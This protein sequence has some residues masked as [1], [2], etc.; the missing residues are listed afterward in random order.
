MDKTEKNSSNELDAKKRKWLLIF[1]VIIL[2]VITASASGWFI[3][4]FYQNDS[5]LMSINTRFYDLVLLAMIVPLSVIMFILAYR[6]RLWAKVF[7]LGIIVYLAF[8]YGFYAFACY[9]NNLFLIYITLISLS[10]FCI[11][12]GYTDVAQKIT[13]E[14][15]QILMRIISAA[16]LFIAISGY[17]FWLN[18]V[19]DFIIKGESSK[20]LKEM[21][22][23]ANIAQVLDMAFILPLTIGGAINLWKYHSNGLAISAMMLVFYILIGI[24]VI[25]M[26][27]GLYGTT[28]ME[29]DIGKVIG[30]GFNAAIC[31][32]LAIFTYKNL[33][34]Q[35]EK[36]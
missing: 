19:I 17:T 9:Q 10:V 22:I 18:D 25:T 31:F 29:M 1:P 16:L 13:I 4:N 12:R 27:F 34:K 32:V 35:G 8:S 30:F 3:D 11:F 5:S 26:E 14:E 6:G 23:P 28:G 20:Y 24:T 36:I 21:N 15:K 7:L 33:S 2:L